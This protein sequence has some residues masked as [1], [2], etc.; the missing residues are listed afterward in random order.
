M[1]AEANAALPPATTT[2]G[3]KEEEEEVVVHWRMDGGY[4]V[5]VTG[6]LYTN[7]GA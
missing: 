7:F 3:G 2:E 1:Y 4:R 6:L 5:S